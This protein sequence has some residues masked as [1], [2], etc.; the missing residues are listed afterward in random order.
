LLKKSIGLTPEQA[1]DVAEALKGRFVMKQPHVPRLVLTAGDY[2]GMGEAIGL[3]KITDLFRTTGRGVLLRQSRTASAED[4]KN[5]NVVLL[6]S[7]WVN[8][9][10]GKVP[11]KEDFVYTPNATIA[12]TSPRS[13]ESKEYK[14]EFG[15]RAGDLTVDYALVTV[16]PNLSNE[17]TIMV[18][19]G[20]HSEGT[21]A[22]AE[23]VTS[24]SN[25]S[26]LNNRLRETGGAAGPLR[27][28]Q[29]LLKVGVE[30][31]IPTTISVVA[32]HELRVGSQ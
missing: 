25:L 18:L 24:K 22:A 15:E 23:F 21:E 3:H 27:H 26:D 13:G 29:V 9:W 5:H 6:G 16:K 31:G 11:V 28:Y 17:D 2:T 7:V 4:L 30:N 12:N 20:I 1:S 19:A 8:D 32:L 10:S 14:P